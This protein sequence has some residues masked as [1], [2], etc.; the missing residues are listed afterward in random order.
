MSSQETFL[1]SGTTC[2]YITINNAYV[3]ISI[4]AVRQQ[5]RKFLAYQHIN[6][7]RI[8]NLAATKCYP[9]FQIHPTRVEQTTNKE[10]DCWVANS[11]NNLS[12]GDWVQMV[13]LNTNIT[14]RALAVKDG[15]LCKLINTQLAD[16][17]LEIRLNAK[18]H[19]LQA[20]GLSRRT[21]T[22]IALGI[23]EGFVETA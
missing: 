18:P 2:Q 6:V 19:I 10:Y 23:T 7:C 1:R 11:P 22:K 16:F 21:D 9:A 20:S 4:V 8:L 17:R 15:Q 12:V 13:Y 3:L 5:C 14:C